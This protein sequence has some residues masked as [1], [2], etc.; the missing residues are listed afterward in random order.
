MDVSD[1][2]TDEFDLFVCDAN[3][4]FSEWQ[5]NGKTFRELRDEIS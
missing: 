2:F 4:G 3:G 5:D 1:I